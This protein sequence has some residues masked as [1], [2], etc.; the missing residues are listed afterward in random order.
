M[1]PS[2]LLKIAETEFKQGAKVE[3]I[4]SLEVIK[5]PSITYEIPKANIQVTRPPEIKLNP[6]PRPSLKIINQSKVPQSTI[7]KTDIN[8]TSKNNNET[9][10]TE[11]VGRAPGWWT[12]LSNIWSPFPNPG[13][14]AFGLNLS[15]GGSA[16]SDILPWLG[17]VPNQAGE[18]QILIDPFGIQ[19]I[20]S[21]V[22]SQTVNEVQGAIDKFKEN[23]G[24]N[25][26]LPDFGDLGKWLLIGGGLLLL[27][28]ILPKLIPQRR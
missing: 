25:I 10:N 20:G 24:L 23:T 8:P 15:G 4:G 7:K 14:I 17:N 27:I 11:L 18:N 5:K 13:D 21:N 2:Q 9:D 22:P 28:L 3:R 19:D 1:L 16:Y 6:S 26:N 12:F